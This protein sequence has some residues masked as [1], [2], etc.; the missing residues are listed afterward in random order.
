MYILRCANDSY[1]IGSTTELDQRIIQHKNGFGSNYT[2]KHLPVE[3]VY[4]EL[5]DRIDLAFYRE[6]QV[7]KWS[8]KKKLAL[9]NGNKEEL[10]RLARNR[11]D[12]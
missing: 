3:L 12:F 5:F 6:H 8:A 1:Y 11:G 9:I 7:K 2:K 10:V 4:Y